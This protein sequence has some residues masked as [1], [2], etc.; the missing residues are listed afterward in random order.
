MLIVYLLSHGGVSESF[1]SPCRF[2]GIVPGRLLDISR[3]RPNW[4]CRASSARSGVPALTRASRSSVGSGGD[5]ESRRNS[6]RRNS[7]R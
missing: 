6:T 5:G 3:Y 7:R 1:H 2:A 4:K